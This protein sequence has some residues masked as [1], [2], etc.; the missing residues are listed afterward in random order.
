MDGTYRKE[1]IAD[2][3]GEL[4]M[5]ALG[6]VAYK[7][8]F[9]SEPILKLEVAA[10]A[11]FDYLLG[12]FVHALIYYDT[13]MWKEKATAVDTKMVALISSTFLQNY[14]FRADGLKESDKLYLRL[15]LATDYVSGMTD[16]Y[17]KRLYRELRGID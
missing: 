10:D 5:D 12:S 15:L 17:A 2:T 3:P 8:A 7:H 9:I 11:I 13:D 16:G 4:I 14:H 6:R 1:L